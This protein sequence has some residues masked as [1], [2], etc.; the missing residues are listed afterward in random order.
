MVFDPQRPASSVDANASRYNAG[1]PRRD[2]RDV[3]SNI[4]HAYDGLH[5]IHAIL[6]YLNLTKQYVPGIGQLL[7]EAKHTYEQGLARYHASEYERSQEFAAACRCLSQ[8]VEILLSR[9]LR[10][11]TSYA[12]L[13]PPPPERQSTWKQSDRVENS[14]N[15]VESA[16]ARL[17]WL[18]E[19]GTLPLE[20]RT[21]VRKIVSWGETLCHQTRHIYRR[22][23]VED[24]RELLR[25]A[26][27]AAQ[28]AEHICRN[29]YIALP[30]NS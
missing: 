9:T 7:D 6:A 16:L 2:K 19:N 13:V 12:S 21:Q 18:M 4:E 3:A 15:E 11:D 17:H 26:N 27:F 14:L 24:A 20:D 8:V 23:L 5:R 30:R 29:W 28:S 1:S 10:S 22:G 25:A